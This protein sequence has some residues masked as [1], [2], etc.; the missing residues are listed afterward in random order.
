MA[1]VDVFKFKVLLGLNWIL[2][3]DTQYAIQDIFV[4]TCNIV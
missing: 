3:M 1:E 2:A 4:G